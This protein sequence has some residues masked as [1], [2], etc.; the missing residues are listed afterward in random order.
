MGQVTTKLVPIEAILRDQVVADLYV[1]D[2]MSRKAAHGLLRSL[3]DQLEHTAGARVD[4]SYIG[5]DLL[6]DLVTSS[7]LRVVSS[8]DGP[9]L[10]DE[11]TGATHRVWRDD[12][13]T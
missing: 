11:T 6:I 10:E 13:E 12:A 5:N 3:W 8:E 2:T 1:Q 9:L 4:Q 7:S